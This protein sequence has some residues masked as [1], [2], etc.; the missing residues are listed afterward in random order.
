MP[1][2]PDIREI[3]EE[4]KRLLQTASVPPIRF[5]VF[6]LAINLVLDLISSAVSFSVGDTFS[7]TSLSLSFSFISI[8]VSLL[9]VVLLAGYTHYCLRIYGGQTL[10]YKSLFDAF[11]F[12]G[13]VVLLSLLQAL[14]IAFGL[15]LFIAPGIYLAFSYTFA[16]YHLCEEPDIQVVEAMRR[17][18]LE[19]QGYKWPLFLL[20]LSFWPLLLLA[21]LVLGGCETLL[22]RA[23][24]DTLSGNLLYT[25][26]AGVLSGCAEAYL[27]PYMQLSQVGFYRCVTAG[28][29][30]DP[31]QGTEL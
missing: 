6:F 15:I 27:M 13:K 17:S 18:R 26:I 23:L 2:Q 7:F 22:I 29:I 12:A 28:R 3:R 25:L 31:L 8:L 19:I 5:T 24:P 10:P 16:L 20:L 1:V 4:A 11:P 14:L 9:S 21:G 30:D